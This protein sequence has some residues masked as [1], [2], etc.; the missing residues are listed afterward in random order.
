MRE[1]IKSLSQ[2]L[3]KAQ[4]KTDGLEKELD[5]LKKALLEK[6]SALDRAE[7]ELQR[8]KRQTLDVY[9]LCLKKNK[10]RGNSIKKA[11]VLQQKLAELQSENFLLRQQLGDAQNK[12]AQERMRTE[13]Q[14]QGELADAVRKQHTAETALQ[15]STHQ[16]SRLKEENS[17]LQEDLD[18]AK[19]KVYKGCQHVNVSEA[20]LRHGRAVMLQEE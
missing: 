10:K 13:A 3:S 5:Q 18:K 1:E 16:C 11:E 6:T 2:R 15:D 7:R 4:K 19:A 8:S 12:A 14:L 9:A 17:R 20:V